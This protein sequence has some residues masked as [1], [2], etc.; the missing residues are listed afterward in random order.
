MVS[1]VEDFKQKQYRVLVGLSHPDNVRGLMSIASVFARRQQG[2]II[3]MSVLLTPADTPPDEQARARAEAVVAQAE[4][5][6]AE[7][8]IAVDPVVEPAPDV[9]AGIMQFL[10]HTGADLT[11]LGFSPPAIPSA[12]DAQA[13]ARITEAL[14]GLV[15]GSLA[16]VA[17]PRDPHDDLRLLVPLTPSSDPAVGR[18]LARI[19]AL[20]GGASITFLGM[21]PDSLSAEEFA[22]AAASLRE[23]VEAL[24]LDETED[25]HLA[26]DDATHCLFG[27]EV[28][29]MG[30]DDARAAFMIRAK[31]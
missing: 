10:A 27:A 7:L 20:L 1:A 17:F 11:L 5:F 22:A 25:I 18:D 6:G 3:A 2:R 8:G 9:P 23:S 14:A 4:D 30:G 13:P 16:I 29:Q 19:A 24:D 21:L 15:G 28:Q 31:L 26:C 12:D